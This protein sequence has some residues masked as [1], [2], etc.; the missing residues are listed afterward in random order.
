M[1]EKQND[2]NLKWSP[3]FPLLQDE[4]MICPQRAEI[5]T[6]F[7]K[8]IYY[9]SSEEKIAVKELFESCERFK[10]CRIQP[11]SATPCLKT[12]AGVL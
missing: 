3:P 5:V 7:L 12:S 6:K 1:D 10:E 2:N 4:D 11:R 9:E 8:D